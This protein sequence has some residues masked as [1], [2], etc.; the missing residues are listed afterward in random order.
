MKEEILFSNKINQVEFLRSRS[1][2]GNHSFNLKV[3]NTANLANEVLERAGVVLNEQYQSLEDMTFNIL[4]IIRGSEFSD[5]FIAYEDV[6][7]L[8]G[9]ISQIKMSILDENEFDSI[10]SGYQNEENIRIISYVLK[11]L[12]ETSYLDKATLVKMA[13]KNSSNVF[14]KVKYLVEEYEELSFVEKELLKLLKAEEVSIFNYFN[15]KENTIKK[16][17]KY[18]GEENEVEEIFT[19]I[20]EEKIPLDKCLL[21]LANDSTYVPIIEKFS[22]QFNIPITFSTGVPILKSKPFKLFELLKRLSNENFYSVEGFKELFKGNLLNFGEE[23]EN[24][25]A[26]LIKYL[27]EILGRLKIGFKENNNEKIKNLLEDENYLFLLE[28]I[29]GI[30]TS[31]K[32]LNL[33]KDW[34]VLFSGYMEEGITSFFKNYVLCE[35]SLDE[36]AKAIIINYL[37]RTENLYIEKNGQKTPDPITESYLNSIAN[38]FLFLEVSKPGFLHV[39]NLESSFSFSRENV[40][41]L[42]MDS[43]NFPGNRI[44]SYLLNDEQKCLLDKNAITSEKRLANINFSFDCMTKFIGE[45]IFISYSYF[46]LIE[47]KEVNPSSKIYSILNSKPSLFNNIHPNYFSGKLKKINKTGR[48]YFNRNLLESKIIELMNSTESLVDKVEISATSLEK[49]VACPLRFYGEKILKIN[50]PFEE[51]YS[52]NIPSNDFGK[53]AHYILS[54]YKDPNFEELVIKVFNSYLLLNIPTMDVKRDFDLFLN[55]CLNGREYLKRF[56]NVIEFEDPNHRLEFKYKGRLQFTGRFDALGITTNMKGEDEYVLIDFKTDKFDSRDTK[57][58]EDKIQ[59]LFYLFAIN[60]N[61]N[62][63]RINVKKGEYFYL[64]FGK[65]LSVEWDPKHN[66]IDSLFTT[67]KIEELYNDLETRTFPAKPI[68]TAAYDSRYCPLKEIFGEKC[69]GEDWKWD[70]I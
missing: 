3:M 24:K 56:K 31:E 7:N 5:K 19:K 30:E 21:V 9:I 59:M 8:S 16:I 41:V 60:H 13:I 42:G 15:K 2:E 12:N 55:A 57:N 25:K 46:N 54:K 50:K 39:I 66:D 69:K 53:L 68:N 34:L 67:N 20:F 48:E 35:N 26:F 6:S 17:S 22:K 36:F 43:S 23:N 33:I 37:E 29:I 38:N 45:N 51:R 49:F 61:E 44:E 52:K 58:P 32:K 14:I 4:K 47:V 65:I 28:S 18:Y 10:L 62:S 1:R 27:P 40:F 11:K 70:K 63:N 64:N